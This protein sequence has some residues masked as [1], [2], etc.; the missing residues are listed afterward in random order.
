M[1]V[2]VGVVLL[3][4]AAVAIVVVAVNVSVVLVGHAPTLADTKKW[5]EDMASGWI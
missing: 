4:A 2:G 3:V 1:V 5:T